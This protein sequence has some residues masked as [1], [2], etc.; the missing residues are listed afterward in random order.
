MN[1]RFWVS[2]TILRLATRCNFP[3]V[4]GLETLSNIPLAQALALLL[5]LALTLVLV[6]AGE[7]GE[8]GEIF[9]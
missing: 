4:P 6:L 3:P 2:E 8:L 1:R 7:I 9:W 5:N